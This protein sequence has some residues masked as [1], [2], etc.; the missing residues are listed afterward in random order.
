MQPAKSHSLV[1]VIRFIIV[2][3]TKMATRREWGEV[4]ITVQ[5]G[6]IITV[7]TKQSYQNTLPVDAQ[8]ADKIADQR[9]R[10]LAATG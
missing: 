4:V 1:D 3:L 8:D 5:Q 7:T 10:S 6:Q 2:T 9:L